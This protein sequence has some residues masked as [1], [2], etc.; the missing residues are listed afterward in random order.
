MQR[1]VHIANEVQK[2]FQSDRSLFG[3][4]CGVAQFRRE[5]L[6]LVDDAII[7]WSVGSDRPVRNGR[8][9][10]ARGMQIRRGNFDV[11][12][13]PQAGFLPGSV[14]VRVSE[15]IGQVAS[16]ATSCAVR[17]SVSAASM[18][19]TCLRT[20][21]SRKDCAIRATTWCPSSPM[22]LRVVVE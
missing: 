3:I 9:I 2:E 19:S 5:L 1:L 13:A 22:R 14:L 15:L 8:M 12:E 10:E 7:G 16:D 20:S 21:G 17:G 11:D 18:A 6:D 4:G